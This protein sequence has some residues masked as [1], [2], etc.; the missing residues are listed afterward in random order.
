METFFFSPVVTDNIVYFGSQDNNL[1]AVE[2]ETGNQQWVFETDGVISSSPTVANGTVFISSDTNLYAVDAETG[3]QQWQN[4]SKDRPFTSPT[5]ADDTLF[6]GN[7]DGNLYAINT[8]NG[9]QRWAFESNGRNQSSPTVAGSTVFV[10]SQ[11]ACLYALDAET[12]SEEWVF[13]TESA[14]ASSPTI[15]DGT[16]FIGSYDG[17][18]YAVDA[19]R[20]SHSSS[21]SRVKLG[22]FGHHGDWQY[23]FQSITISEEKQN[24]SQEESMSDDQKTGDEASIQTNEPESSEST[25]SLG[26]NNIPTKTIGGIGAMVTIGGSMYAWRRSRQ[27]DEETD[28]N[29]ATRATNNT[30]TG[31]SPSDSATEDAA[32]DSAQL[33]GRASKLLT[34]ADEA[35]ADGQYQQAAE[36]YEE[37]INHLEQATVEGDDDEE[38]KKE[39]KSEIENITA[40]LESVN[41]VIEARESVTTTLQAAERSFKEGIARYAAGEQTVARIRFR[42]ARDAFEEAQQTITESDTELLAQAIEVS[43]EQEAAL[44]SLA[45]KELAVLDDSTI[46]TL[47]AVDIESLTSLKTDPEKMTPPVIS[48]LEESDEVSSEEAAL[49]TILSWWY[50]GTS[51][52]FTS[53]TVISRRYEQADYGFNQSR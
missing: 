3:D 22:T 11:D 4:I 20:L 44:P 33:Q 49:L 6:V 32:R 40:S 29:T 38:I 39:L 27:A 10:G 42:Q 15:V 19:M 8:E 26:A 14:S 34:Q 45:L 31:N 16:A 47:A 28:I 7:T 21:D 9:D 53:E 24:N 12:G 17:N 18:I 2:A 51:R 35:E 36:A 41:A 50:E 37:A 30:T 43:F 1:Y 5:V 48:D 52:K 13:N 25:S 46:E 23:A